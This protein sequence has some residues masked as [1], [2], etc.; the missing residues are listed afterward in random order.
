MSAFDLLMKLFRDTGRRTGT[1]VRKPA[2]CRP[3]L[4]ALEERSLLSSSFGPPVTLPVGSQPNT[5]VTADLNGDGKQDVVV[6]NEGE[7]PDRVSSV[8]VLL[9]NGDGSFGPA[10]TTS[11]LPGATS[12][13][14]GDFNRDGK[15]DLAVTSGLNNSVEI[16]QGNGDGTFQ[17][18]PLVIPVGTQQN[19]M[20]SIQPVAVGDFLHNG[21]LDLAVANPGSN[22]VSVL[23]GN[24]DG[25]F[26]PRV[27]YPV[28][29]VPLSVAALDLGNGHVD[30]VVANH[31]SSDVSVLVG[32]GDGTFQPAQNI[33]V[34]AQAFGLDSHPLTLRG[35]DFN[36]DGKPDVLI[37][38]F[39]GADA[40]E[41]LV[42]VL[43]GNGDGTLRSPITRDVGFGSIGLAV[44]DFDGDGKLDFAMSE[45]FGGQLRVF[46]GN[47]D[48][49]FGSPRA[50]ASGGAFP[51]SPA[52]GDFNGDG[53]P[54]LVVPIPFSNAVGVLLNTSG[55][56]AATTTTLNT[57]VPA[58][59]FGQAQTLTANVSSPA[60]TPTGNVT[61]FDGKTALGSAP[62]N[63]AG[64]ATLTVALA[65]GNHVLTASF[66][67]SNAFDPST[68]AAVAGTV[69]PAATAVVLSASTNPVRTGAPVT[70][71]ATVTA[72][73]PGAGTPTGTVTFFDGGTVLGTVKVN[74]NGQAS[75]T[76]SLAIVGS[77]AIKAAY[78]GDSNFTAGS[79]TIAE[80][81]V[82]RRSSHTALAASANPVALGQSVTFTAT[83]SADSGTGTPT[84]TITFTDGNVVLA[85]VTLRRG[86]AT[87]AWRFATVVGHTIKAAYS[88]DG[89]FDSNS[90]SLTEQVN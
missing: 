25:T 17:A 40:G 77:H 57:S 27:E 34:K 31:D 45:A 30:L 9:G 36:G 53:R 72:V 32:N 6:L 19:F 47:G 24:G 51:G 8:S 82:T 49:T 62:L 2:R 29:T 10:I 43:L 55:Q 5:V 15:A 41:S 23:L 68:S 59:V 54:D 89:T 66:G 21:K 87:L 73:A 44:N 58:A 52:S 61:F 63:A 22:T 88:G 81:V 1:T 11:L 26:G 85:V 69:S 78:S 64:Q 56:A 46:P 37:S 42:T 90:Q 50:F 18:N 7:F 67:G 35:G 3:T 86:K 79:Q 70:F 20:G 48:G 16:L 14:V 4:E 65:I 33:D 80:Q 74:A 28:G 84:G 39:A 76:L 38:Q 12:A 13:A 75:L 71:T 83:V 60:G